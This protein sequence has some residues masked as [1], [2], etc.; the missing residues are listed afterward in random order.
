MKTITLIVSLLLTGFTLPLQAQEILMEVAF[1][2]D[3]TDQVR[4][5]VGGAVADKKRQEIHN[6]SKVGNVTIDPKIF[7]KMEQELGGPYYFKVEKYGI[8]DLRKV[9]LTDVKKNTSIKGLYSVAKREFIFASAA[10]QRHN[11]NCG[12]VSL[13]TIKGKF[14]SDFNKLESGE[15]SLGFIAGCE[16][17][18]IGAG[19]TFFFSGTSASDVMV[20]QNIAGTGIISLPEDSKEIKALLTDNKWIPVLSVI[21]GTKIQA[22]PTDFANF[23][24]D[25]TY[26]S[27]LLGIAEKGTWEYDADVRS[28]TLKLSKSTNTYFIT[29]LSDTLLKLH[30]FNDEF[31]LRPEKKTVINPDDY[32]AKTNLLAG[33]WKIKSHRNGLIKIGH[34]P[35]DFVKF[36]HDGTYEHTAFGIYAKGTWKWDEKEETVTIQCN[37]GSVWNIKKLDVKIL[38][39]HK[40][41]DEHIEL[42]KP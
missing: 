38:N 13:G 22:K 9:T 27:A 3:W 31:I 37:G 1:K 41:K 19:A 30:S 8:G 5:S 15:F 21:K 40:W 29:E 26:N 2:V 11:K 39:M 12:S 18:L 24:S 35:L 7:A 42:Y 33:E 36:Y 28:L 4:I 20:S 25:G 17:V 34:K 32:S 6:G 23:N 14:S 10:G 16:P